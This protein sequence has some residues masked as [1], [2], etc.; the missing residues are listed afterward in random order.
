VS[1]TILNQNPIQAAVAKGMAH[2]PQLKL[3]KSLP[4]NARIQEAQAAATH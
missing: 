2:N 4:E 3:G 1:P